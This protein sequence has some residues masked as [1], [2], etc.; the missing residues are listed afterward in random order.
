MNFWNWNKSINKYGFTIF[1]FNLQIIP[2]QFELCILNFEMEHKNYNYR[3]NIKDSSSTSK[4]K[5]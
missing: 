5:Q 4:E 3:D 2:F 1:R